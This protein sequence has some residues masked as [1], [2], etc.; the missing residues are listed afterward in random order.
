MADM[1]NFVKLA[2]SNDHRIAVRKH[3]GSSGGLNNVLD[4]CEDVYYDTDNAPV[5]NYDLN[6][7]AYVALC[8]T[9]ERVNY[10]CRSCWF[11]YNLPTCFAYLSAHYNA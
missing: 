9:K 6:A 3:N 10:I 8:E 1:K 2:G 7:P 4:F 5:K 11:R